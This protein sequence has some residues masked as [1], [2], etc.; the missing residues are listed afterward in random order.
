MISC[1]DL[2]GLVWTCLDLFGLVWTFWTCLEFDK[3]T[4]YLSEFSLFLALK[5]KNYWLVL[6]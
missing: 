6:F 1:L 3:R 2:F 4:V 5:N